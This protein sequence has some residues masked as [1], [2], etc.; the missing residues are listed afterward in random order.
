[1]ALYASR[2]QKH[3]FRTFVLSVGIFGNIARLFRWDRSGVVVSKPIMYSE[4]GNRELSEF[5][6]RFD[7]SDR[8]QRGWDPTVSNATPGQSAALTNAV[9]TAMDKG[10][11]KFL[12]SLLRSIGDEVKYPRKKIVIF[13]PKTGEQLSYLVG[14]STVPPKSLT[15]RCTRG[16]VAMETESKRLV[17]LKDTWRRNV[18]GMGP[19]SHWFDKPFHP[20]T[21]HCSLFFQQR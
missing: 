1:M 12:E 5:F 18:L 17:F 16:F 2:M 19:E 9:E 15:G 20:A 7:L 10:K 14:N 4:E 6:R 3:Q 21:F 13:H 8:T 11:D